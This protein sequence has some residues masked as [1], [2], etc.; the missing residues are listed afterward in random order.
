M[1][2]SIISGMGLQKKHGHSHPPSQQSI[3]TFL[4]NLPRE[5]HIPASLEH[6]ITEYPSLMA[7]DSSLDMKRVT[8]LFQ[9]AASRTTLLALNI[10][11]II[12]ISS[13]IW[14]I[15]KTRERL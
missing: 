2:H 8:N 15:W 12:L 5:M 14:S 9:S 1:N 7:R 10:V 13:P 11:Q 6:V 3:R 4:L